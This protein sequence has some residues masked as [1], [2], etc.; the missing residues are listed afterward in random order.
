MNV[1]GSKLNATVFL[2]DDQP[3]I[4]EL[5]ERIATEMGFDAQ[6][7][8]CAEAFL[9]SY[10]SS[11]PGCLVLDLRMPGMSGVELQQELAR[12]G[13]YLPI[14]VVTG[15]ADL[16]D[17]IQSVRLGVFDILQKPVQ[18]EELSKAIR[19]A[20]QHD[21]HVRTVRQ[22]LQQLTPKEREVVRLLLSGL[23]MKHIAARLG[24]TFATV[25]KHRARA[26]EK[27]NVENDVELTEWVLPVAEKVGLNELLEQQPCSAPHF[28]H[29]PCVDYNCGLLEKQRYACWNTK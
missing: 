15:Y 3:E 17:C 22:A 24:V 14:I 21:W 4:L 12:R 5:F 29:T 28:S 6:K 26:L 1:Q 25:A 7:Y 16:S 11:Q 20:V 19:G 23:E 13:I 18:P 9:Q 10:D 2:V 27:L 8:S